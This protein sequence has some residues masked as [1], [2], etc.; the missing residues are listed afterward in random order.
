LWGEALRLTSLLETIF[1]ALRAALLFLAVYTVSTGAILLVVR[2]PKLP[3]LS[4]AVL[5]LP[6]IAAVMPVTDWYDGR[7]PRL[8]SSPR[9][10]SLPVD[11]LARID[12]AA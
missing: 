10:E 11:D 12:R 3:I 2:L 6:I 9:V 1:T 4:Y 7:G 8:G 5:A